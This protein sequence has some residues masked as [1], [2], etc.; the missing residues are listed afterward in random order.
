MFFVCSINDI[1]RV[2][3]G[4]GWGLVR[5]SGEGAHKA[6]LFRRRNFQVL[7]KRRTV[8]TAVTINL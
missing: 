1:E 4:M 3:V 5:A 6:V 7:E 2:G 8:R